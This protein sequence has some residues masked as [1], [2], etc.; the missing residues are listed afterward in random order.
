[1]SLGNGVG[2]YYM[3]PSSVSNVVTGGNQFL[4]VDVTGPWRFLCSKDRFD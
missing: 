3:V 4:A 2:Y 1:M